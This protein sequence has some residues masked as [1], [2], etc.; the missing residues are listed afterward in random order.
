MVI[1]CTGETTQAYAVLQSILNKL[2]LKLNEE[3]T[4]I[5][6]S[7]KEVFGF[8]GFNVGIVKAKQSGK[9]FPLVEPSDKALKSIK[10]KIKF[11]T[12]RDMNPVPIEVIIDML[13]KTARGWSNYF[14]YGHG[15]RKMKK[16][17]YYLEES[18]RLHLRYRHKLNNRGPLIAV[19]RGAIFMTIW[20]YIKCQSLRPGKMYMLEEEEHRKAV[21]G[22]TACPV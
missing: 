2:E 14:H 9:P 20:D 5:R 7:R 16:I 12:R 11:Y 18:L 21:C 1:L 22:R 19:F 8:L 4:R 10:Q 3:K 13:N 17:K 6:D 15:H